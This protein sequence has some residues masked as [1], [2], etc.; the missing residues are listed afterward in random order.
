MR[1]F[2]LVSKTTNASPNRGIGL[3]DHKSDV[4]LKAPFDVG[5]YPTITVCFLILIFIDV[6]ASVIITKLRKLN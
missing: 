1:I 3:S 5:T 2:I 6:F 4:M